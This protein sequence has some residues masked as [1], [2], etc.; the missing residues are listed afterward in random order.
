MHRA[1]NQKHHK[2]QHLQYSPFKD[3]RVQKH[4]ELNV[5][6]AKIMNIHVI[7]ADL[8]SYPYKNVSYGI[9]QAI[10]RYGNASGQI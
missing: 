8:K 9:F 7:L 5:F 3:A 10:A 4:M 2:V 1:K 6:K